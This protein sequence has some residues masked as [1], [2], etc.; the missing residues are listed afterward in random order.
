MVE[1]L[2]ITLQ[3]RQTF[4]S[5]LTVLL[6]SKTAVVM[7]L[8]KAMFLVSENIEAELQL[9]ALCFSTKKVNAPVLATYTHLVRPLH[10][11]KSGTIHIFCRPDWR[12]NCCFPVISFA[13][14]LWLIFIKLTISCCLVSLYFVASRFQHCMIFL[15]FRTWVKVVAEPY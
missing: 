1:I 10:L 4:S 7:I 13:L 15:G 11:N 9:L 5:N 3:A 8:I 2:R 6:A 14:I 12:S